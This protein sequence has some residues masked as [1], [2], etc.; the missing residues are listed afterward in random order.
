[1]SPAAHDAVRALL[2]AI[3]TVAVYLVGFLVVV[4]R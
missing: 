3:V 4:L 2:M 1:M